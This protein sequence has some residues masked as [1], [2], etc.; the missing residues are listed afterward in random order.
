[1]YERYQLSAG[2]VLFSGAEFAVGLGNALC[3][4]TSVSHREK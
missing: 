2:F 3:E 4:S 1:M